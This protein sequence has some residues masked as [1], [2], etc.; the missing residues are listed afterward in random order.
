MSQAG[1]SIKEILEVTEGKLIC[2]K[3]F[4]PCFVPSR[5]ISTDSRNIEKGDF[6]IALQGR[7]FNGHRFI[8]EVNKKGACGAI[9][10]QTASL[11]SPHFFSLK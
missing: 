1:L 9:I 3:G 4:S 6:F 5:K 11:P 8:K 7:R 10:S 2:K